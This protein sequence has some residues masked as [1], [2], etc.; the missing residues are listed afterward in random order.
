MEGQMT[1]EGMTADLEAMKKAGIGGGIFLEV[2]IGIPVGPVRYMSP[3]W[4]DMI[5]YAVKEA[6]RLGLAID[7]GT[8]P[9]WCGTGGPWVTPDQ[10][11]QHLV[12]TQ[13]YATGP[14]HFTGKLA[15]PRPRVPF[16]GMGTLTPSLR[17]QWDSFYKDVVVLAAPMPWVPTRPLTQLDDKSL[18]YRAPYSSQPG[19]PPYLLPEKRS[20]PAEAA[21]QSSEVIDLTSRLR[22]DGTLDWSVPTGQWTIF[23]FGRTLTGQTTRPAPDAGLGF[24][25]DKFETEGIQA[26]LSTFVDAVLKVVGPHRKPDR[27]LTALHFDSWEM[28]SQNWSANFRSLFQK[29][30]GYDPIRYLPVMAGSIVD[31]VQVSE[32][33]LWDLRQTSQ[34]LIIDNH[35]KTIKRKARENGLALSVEPYDMNPASDLALG[36]VADEPMCEFWSKGYGFNSEYSCF[37]AVSIAH[38]MGKKVVGA[39]AFTSDDRDAWL[40]HPASMKEQGDWALANGI[41]KFYF[42]RYQHQPKLDELPGMTMGPYGVHWER[43]QTWWDMA[44]AYHQ[45]LARCQSLLREGLPVADILYLAPEGAPNVFQPPSSATIGTELPDRR[46]YNFD[47]CDPEALITRATVKNGR[48]VFPDGMSYRVLVLPRTDTMTPRLLR[49]IGSLA[50]A[51]ATVVG[52]P[53]TSSPSLVGYPEVDRQVKRLAAETWAK[54][55]VIRDPIVAVE[56]PTLSHAEWIWEN[57]GNAAVSAAV[58][59]RVF[60]KAFKVPRDAKVISA[61][62]AFTA[63]NSFRLS[64]NGKLVARGSN[65]HRVEV[66]DAKDLI[67]PGTNWIEVS[68]T[69]DGPNE[70]PAALI[71]NLEIRFADGTRRSLPTDESWT[72]EG[73][74]AK[75]L[76]PWTM[77]PWSLNA[78]ALP[79]PEFYPTYDVVAKI[80]SDRGTIPDLQSRDTLRYSH[81]RTKEADLYFIGNRQNTELTR[82]ATF[83]VTG[84][85]PEW[86]DPKTGERRLL[87]AFSIGPKS[88]TVPLRL[89]P[90]ESGFVVFQ[91]PT[92]LKSG[93]GTNFPR[94]MDVAKIDGPWQVS[95]DPTLRGPERVEFNRLLDWRNHPDPSIRHYSGK[96]TYTAR[97][98]ASGRA[99]LLSL[100]RV[101]NAATVRLNGRDLG[102]LWS[103]PWQLAIPRGTLKPMGNVLE[104]TVAN[105]WVNRLVGDASLPP[106]QRLT[107]TT[108]SPFRP[109]SPLVESGLLGPVTLRRRR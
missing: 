90:H 98:D 39:E 16:F 1:R 43:T 71:G 17:K 47:G 80:L 77:S 48:I 10:A 42:H 75:A 8:G 14:S 72:V 62:G 103:A 35:L 109:S 50:K 28:G 18:V 84:R 82:N 30:R 12:S 31:S 96:A 85:Q 64:I 52:N 51:G 22:S 76:G 83:R 69:N 29:R 87:P 23:R 54:S 34:E 86:W 20:V 95:F 106:A 107:K 33:F 56:T 101:A 27:G 79:R 49:K 68:A 70:N 6:D 59:T 78:G 60:V 26:H 2:N 67:V 36:G 24:E 61:K 46:G 105:L 73:A 55:K 45:Y 108:W 37:E 41:N 15:Q 4:L 44:P 25:T 5:G 92:R 58:G 13:T 38:T 21:I 97:F 9:G 94:R 91:R 89:A 19:V 7:F 57:K 100:G 99:D 11:M 32:R 104:I 102:T 63:D 53:P 81:R 88:T 3:E 40:Q 93:R 66:F 65:F 74:R